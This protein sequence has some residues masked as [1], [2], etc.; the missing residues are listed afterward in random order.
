MTI[1]ID[2]A[3]GEGGGQILRTSLTLSALTGQPFTISNIRANRKQPGLRPQHLTA[4]QAIAQLTR[5]HVEGDSLNSQLLSFHPQDLCSGR[6]HFTIPTAG[7]LSLVAQSIFLPLCYASGGSQVNLIGGTHVP[8]SPSFHYLTELWMPC[9]ESLGYRGA[10]LLEKAGF[11]PC[12][13]GEVNLRVL[14]PKSLQPFTALNRGNLVQIRGLS[15]VA[16]LDDS[17]AR[18]QKHQALRQLRLLCP[19]TKIKTVQVPSPSKGTFILLKA[20]FDGDGWAC[21]TALGAQGK[22]AEVVADE[23]VEEMLAFLQSNACVDHHLADQILLP[24]ALISGISRF[25]TSRVT[26]HLLTNAHVIRRFLPCQIKIEGNLG[27][28]GVIQIHGR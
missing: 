6:Y 14:S 17:I 9:M 20:M 13:G 10:L 4:V 16:N 7:S 23:A 19:D 8:F 27:Q 11:Y 15:G 1:E 22:R 2:G 3:Y 18:R 25:T 5:A 28:P 12:G 26:Q 24:L 21:F